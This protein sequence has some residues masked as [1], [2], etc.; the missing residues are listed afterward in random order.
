M[1]HLQNIERKILSDEHFDAWLKNKRPN[2]TKLVFTNG[3]FDIIHRGHVV[4]L[5]QSADF[6]THFMVALN[7]DHSVKQNKGT[8]RPLQDHY[9][10]ALIIA[11]FE[12]VDFVVLFNEKT[13]A[14]LIK[15]VVPDVLVKGGDYNVQDIV[16]YDTV[17]NAGGEVR[18]IDFVPGYSTS[19]LIDKF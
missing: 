12:C 1:T 10:R 18:T 3:C 4:Y 13:P 5:T 2:I 16:G 6:G 14:N 11:A 17:T 9:S 7:T 19:K 8:S 15:K